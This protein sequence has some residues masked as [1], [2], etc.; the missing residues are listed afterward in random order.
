MSD[1]FALYAVLHPVVFC[2]SILG[3]KACQ[4]LSKNV[5]LQSVSLTFRQRL[6][7]KHV[8]GCQKR[9]FSKSHK[10]IQEFNFIFSFAWTERKGISSHEFSKMKATLKTRQTAETVN[11]SPPIFISPNFLT[12]RKETIH[13]YPSISIRDRVFYHKHVFNFLRHYQQSTCPTNP[14]YCWTTPIMLW[15]TQ[16]LMV[17]FFPLPYNFTTI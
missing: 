9:G 6:S 2:W 3:E 11:I 17:N 12:P 4:S 16:E 15:V 1:F 14:G 8:S 5:I 7:H 13:L 10:A